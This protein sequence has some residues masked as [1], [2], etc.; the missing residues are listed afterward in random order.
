LKSLEDRSEVIVGGMIGSM[1]V[2]TTR[3]S[4]PNEPNRYANFDLED[5]QGIVRCVCWSNVYKDHVD[6]IQPEAVVVMR[7]R[8][9]K[10]GGGDDIVLVAN[11]VIP[12][13]EADTRFTTGLRLMIDQRRHD[14][15]LLPRIQEV[16]RGY[17]GN[18][19]VFVTL[20]LQSGD[21]VQLKS[22]RHRIS[23]TPELR[24][25]LDDLLGEGSH[26]L[27]ISPPK[28]NVRGGSRRRASAS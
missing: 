14:E 13:D 26:T 23:I 7:A 27:L 4:R 21:M 5:L 2:K 10:R 18:L 6:I 16:L 15:Q 11:E 19:D 24:G 1:N 17:P 22:K 28:P 12:I 8:V 9:E 25:R 20:R 3:N